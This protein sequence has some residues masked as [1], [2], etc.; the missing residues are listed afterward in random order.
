MLKKIYVPNE[1]SSEKKTHRSALA[2]QKPMFHHGFVLIWNKN[3]DTARFLR[4][5]H[6]KTEMAPETFPKK[7]TPRTEYSFLCARYGKK[8][9]NVGS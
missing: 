4:D 1:K 2:Q 8:R 5:L 9:S 6:T 3:R 7:S